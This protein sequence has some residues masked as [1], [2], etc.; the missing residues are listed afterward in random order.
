MLKQKNSNTKYIILVLV[1]FAI[2]AFGIV[3]TA[4]PVS[5]LPTVVTQPDGE[6]LNLFV[7]GD[8]YFNYLHDADGN[9][10][11][12]DYDTGYYTYAE[13][14]NNIVV[15]GDVQVTYDLDDTSPYS[16]SSTTFDTI[17]FEDIPTEY[18]QSRYE[19]S[20]LNET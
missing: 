14:E 17:T 5:N 4:E 20:L 2:I 3:A 10:I 11:I 9:L 16:L 6:E 15:A 13:I 7:S 18:I 19:D 12:K 8:E 1:I